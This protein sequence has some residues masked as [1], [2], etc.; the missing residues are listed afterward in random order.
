MPSHVY[1][2]FSSYHTF[3]VSAHLIRNSQPYPEPVP[4]AGERKHF[5]ASHMPQLHR[6]VT[7]A[8]IS[9]SDPTQFHPSS[10]PTPA[11]PFLSQPKSHQT[12]TPSPSLSP[13]QPTHS[14]T[15]PTARRDCSAGI[16]ALA[17]YHLSHT[18]WLTLSHPGMAKV[19]ASALR[20]HPSTPRHMPHFLIAVVCVAP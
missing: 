13:L 9:S 1:C 16:E 2:I 17:S 3:S 8:T 10:T 12:S 14:P 15:S 20:T 11:R 4:S 6:S 18:H 5:H 7:P 19:S